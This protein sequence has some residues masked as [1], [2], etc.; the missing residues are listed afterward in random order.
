MLEYATEVHLEHVPREVVNDD[1]FWWCCVSVAS[2]TVSLRAAI[3]F[4][5][6]PPVR[7]SG[8]IDVHFVIGAIDRS[9]GS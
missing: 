4:R 7:G 8:F 6:P 1:H 5:V 3:I 9:R 2:V